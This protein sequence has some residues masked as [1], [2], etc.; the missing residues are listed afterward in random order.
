MGLD[1]YS[2]SRHHFISHIHIKIHENFESMKIDDAAS[3]I[4]LL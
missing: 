3:P 2:M 1:F 4:S